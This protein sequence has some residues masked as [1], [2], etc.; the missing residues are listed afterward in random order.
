MENTNNKVPNFIS[1]LDSEK[2]QDIS[3]DELNKL[4]KLN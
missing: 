4:M 3:F 2:E 1:S